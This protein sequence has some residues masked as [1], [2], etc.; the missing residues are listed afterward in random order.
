MALDQGGVTITRNAL[1]NF[2]VDERRTMIDGLPGT[3]LGCSF[4]GPTKS[5]ILRR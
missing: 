2:V 3:E 4:S 1:L 5:G